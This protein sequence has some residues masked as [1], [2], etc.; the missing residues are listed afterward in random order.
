[1]KTSNTDNTPQD[2]SQSTSLFH[3]RNRHQG[4]YD[5]DPLIKILPELDPYVILNK[6]QKRTINF[7]DPKAVYLLN[8]ALLQHQYRL[9]YWEVPSGYLCPAIPGRADYIH[10]VA[11]LLGLENKGN[12]PRGARVRCLDMGVGANCI[13]PLI[14]NKAYGWSFVGSDIDRE[15]IQAA[16][17]NVTENKLDSVI[18]I[19]H[20]KNK[21]E[22]LT[23]IRG[24]EYFDMTI[25]NPPFHASA[26]EAEQ[27]TLRK[28]RNL[29]KDKVKQSVKNFGGMHN[30]LWCQGGEKAFLKRLIYESVDYATQCMWFTTLVSKASNLESVH[31]RLDKVKALDVKTIEMG[32]GNKISRLVAWTFLS[33]KQT[34]NWVAYRWK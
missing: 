23:V 25:C 14:G 17:Q 27:A 24:D 22:I 30:E 10:N 21:N 13:Y 16:Q 4:E 29:N 26:E 6:Y 20:Q 31:R 12:P 8:K 15:S 2:K 3:K 28:Q 11:D 18:E 1:M 5:F 33:P 9:E 32:Q 7:S 34:K 19:R